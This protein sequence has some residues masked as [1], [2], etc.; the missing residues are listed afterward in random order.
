MRP[1]ASSLMG[2]SWLAAVEPALDEAQRRSSLSAT[3]SK[4]SPGASRNGCA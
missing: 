2:L 4:M 3:T 1:G